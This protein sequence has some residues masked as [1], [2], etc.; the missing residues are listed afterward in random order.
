M[1]IFEDLSKSKNMVFNMKKLLNV[2]VDLTLQRRG[3]KKQYEWN[4]LQVL[5]NYAAECKFLPTD[6]S[7]PASTKSF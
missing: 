3:E 4:E 6:I 5:Q 2:G 1:K 7:T